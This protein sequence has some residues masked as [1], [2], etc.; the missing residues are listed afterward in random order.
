MRGIPTL[1]DA[2][3]GLTRTRA[4]APGVHWRHAFPHVTFGAMPQVQF[5]EE[6]LQKLEER[7]PRFDHRAYLVVLA[8]LN[9]VLETLPQRRHISGRELAEGLRTVAIERFGLLARTVLAHWGIHTTEDVGE[10]VFALVENG[11]LVKQEHDRIED[12]R[13]VFDFEEVFEARYPWGAAL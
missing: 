8:A 13:D 5:A 7:D 2:C 3:G 1:P 11:L 12:F 10:V 6:V 9:H 4:G